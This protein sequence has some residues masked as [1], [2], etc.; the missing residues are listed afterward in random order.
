LINCAAGPSVVG[1]REGVVSILGR[2]PECDVVVADDSVSR[3]HARLIV[4]D[5][6]LLE[7]L[8]STNGTKVNARS[9]GVKERVPVAVGTIIELGTATL[10]LQRGV[11]VDAASPPPASSRAPVRHSIA[12][13][14]EAVVNDVTMRNL[15]GLL[16]MIAP[17]P[18]SVLIMG[19]TGVGK[20]VFATAIHR[21]STRATKPFMVISCAALPE[22][23]LEAELFGFEKGSFTG[24][25][26]CK[27]GLFEAADGG[28]VFLDEVGEIP[29]A[30]QAKLLRVIETGEIMRLGSV[31]EKVVDV[32]FLAATNRDLRD[33]ITEGRFRADLFFRLNG[34]SITLPP[35]RSRRADIAPL[36]RHLAERVAKTMGRPSLRLSDTAIASLERRDWPG[37]VRELRNV[38]ER[39][40]VMCRGQEI[41]EADL[42][43]T[44]ALSSWTTP[45]AK[46]IPAPRVHESTTQPLRD[47]IRSLERERIE[48]ALA[49]CGGNQS[50]AARWLGVSRQT[51]IHR[52]EDYGLARPRKKPSA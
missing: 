12:R 45:L 41:G 2:G 22:S 34:V 38:I 14:E 11:R 8:G 4:S 40:I 52:L 47:E 13:A 3:R 9:I 27:T 50:Q 26:N 5:V 32:R 43:A 21:R 31:K 17:T 19:E 49:R 6:L 1:I 33:A 36:A 42:S 28:T 48:E 46:A 7:D 15:Y 10:V 35:L 16:A 24:A 20:E 39:A 23:T 44:D 25:L 51:L 29:L 18:L 30:T 37:N